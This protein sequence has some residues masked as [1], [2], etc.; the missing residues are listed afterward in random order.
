MTKKPSTRAKGPSTPERIHPVTRKAQAGKLLP[1]ATIYG[2]RPDSNEY[3]AWDG[4]QYVLRPSRDN[5]LADDSLMPIGSVRELRVDHPHPG[6]MGQVDVVIPTPQCATRDKN[7]NFYLKNGSYQTIVF[8]EHEYS[9]TRQAG[10]IV[11]VLHEAGGKP[12][13]KADIQ[14]KTK[15][16]KISDS[17]RRLDGPQVW[18]KLIE[19]TKGRKGFYRLHPQAFGHSQ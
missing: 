4:E 5:V 12:V 11:K 7:T 8:C 13:A 6:P 18:K 9:L 3:V 10:A 2:V 15:C 1:G 14:S 16:G 17:F 19:V